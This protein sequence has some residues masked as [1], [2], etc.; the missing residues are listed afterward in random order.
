MHYFI[1]PSCIKSNIGRLQWED[2]FQQTL[3]TFD[4]VKMF[5][6]DSYILFVDSSIGG[7]TDAEKKEIHSRVSVYLDFSTDP[8]AQ[9]I[10]RNGLKSIGETY[11]LS[12]GIHFLKEEN[13]N[14]ITRVYKLGGRVE[15]IS[16]FNIRDYDNTEG[17]YVFKKRLDSWMDKNIQK[18]FNSTHIL[19]TR[20][21]SW[22]PTLMDDYLRV[23]DANIGL[24]NRGFDTEHSHFLNIPK[25]KLLE[26]E[27][28]NVGC[29]VAAGGY[30][31]ID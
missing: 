24:M 2:R 12:R 8:V 7:L 16:S 5:V 14:N 3:K 10:N 1:V 11:L 29:W 15:M 28:L 19:E 31:I 9:E 30:Y 4:S 23:I 20:F 18:Q 21:Y 22:C 25:D 26:F 6:P 17:K 27:H 13:P